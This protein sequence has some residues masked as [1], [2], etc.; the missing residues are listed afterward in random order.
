MNR[1]QSFQNTNRVITGERAF[2]CDCK[3]PLG[4]LASDVEEF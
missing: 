1:N 2:R 4:E 3:S